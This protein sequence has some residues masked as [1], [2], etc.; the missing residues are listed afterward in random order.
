MSST[1]D[2]LLNH[3]DYKID[4]FGAEI[5]IKD[6]VFSPDPTLT[7]SSS[8]ILENIGNL[9]GKIIADIGTGTAT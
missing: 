8:I 9:E 2:K 1:W 7:Y 5:L 4:F 3:E 6:K